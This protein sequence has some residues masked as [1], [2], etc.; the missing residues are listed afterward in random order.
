MKRVLQQS[1]HNKLKQKCGKDLVF[2]DL[3]DIPSLRQSIE[4]MTVLDNFLRYAI[5]QKLGIFKFKN[6]DKA[7]MAV[8]YSV[9]ERKPSYCI[10]YGDCSNDI[11]MIFNPN[12]KP[13]DIR[14]LCLDRMNNPFM[15]PRQVA[16]VYGFEKRMFQYQLRERYVVIP[17]LLK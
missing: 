16:W 1:L 5:S 14:N 17:W 12:N 4:H 8:L 10:L 15:S 11:L 13:L 7:K 6:N 9:K 2:C 3:N